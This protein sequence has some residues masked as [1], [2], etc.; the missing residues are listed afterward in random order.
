MA[1]I[2]NIPN[3]P[4]NPYIQHPAQGYYN[5]LQQEFQQ[6][7]EFPLNVNHSGRG[8]H[9]PFAQKAS[10]L[11]LGNEFVLTITFFNNRKFMYP[12]IFS[13]SIQGL[14]LE[15]DAQQGPSLS[16]S[17]NPRSNNYNQAFSDWEEI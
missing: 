3:Y 17:C 6:G 4:A 16:L 10:A 9:G 5:P 11:Y 7:D 1:I 15:L 2:P 13:E 12:R 14:Q 8:D